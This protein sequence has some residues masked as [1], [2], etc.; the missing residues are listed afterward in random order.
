MNVLL[1]QTNFCMGNFHLSVI[2]QFS[3]K[4]SDNSTNI[5]VYIWVIYGSMQTFFVKKT[6][7]ASSGDFGTSCIMQKN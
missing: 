6:Y 7:W 2:N 1:A 5:V 4:E 3:K